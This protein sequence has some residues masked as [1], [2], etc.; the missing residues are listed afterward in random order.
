MPSICF[1]FQIHQPFRL[2]RYSVFDTDRNYFDDFKNVCLYYRISA[3]IV[4]E[5]KQATHRAFDGQIFAAIHSC[6]YS[7]K[8]FD[9]RWCA[10]CFE[11]NTFKRVDKLV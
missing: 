8:V 2:R 6:R 4:I 9:S 10:Q 1:Y 7:N 5:I 3:W 11:R